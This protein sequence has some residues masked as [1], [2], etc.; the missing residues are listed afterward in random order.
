MP[1]YAILADHSPDI[2]PGSNARSRAR[3][4]EGVGPDNL[5]KVA[6]SVGLEFVVEPLHLDPGHRVIAVAEAPTIEAV[7]EFVYQTGLS[8]WNTVEVVPV[9]PIGEMMGRLFEF[10]TIFE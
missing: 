5:K 9:T 4:M 7:T 3:A 6:D 1:R 10:P 2:C 8:Q